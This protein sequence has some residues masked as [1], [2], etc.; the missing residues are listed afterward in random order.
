MMM[1][2]YNDYRLLS[3]LKPT[4][5]PSAMPSSTASLSPSSI[6]SSEPSLAPTGACGRDHGH[7]QFML[8]G[9]EFMQGITWNVKDIFGNVVISGDGQNPNHVGFYSECILL[10]SCY[11]LSINDSAEATTIE[12][13]NPVLY[14]VIIDENLLVHGHSFRGNQ[15]TMF[16]ALCHQNGDAACTLQREIASPMSMFRLELATDNGRDIAWYLQ[17]GQDQVLQSAGPFGSCQVNTYAMCLPREDCYEF[18]ITDGSGD[19]MNGL[20]TVMFSHGNNMVQNYTG[21]VAGT[22]RVYLGSCYDMI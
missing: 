9:T 16:G 7:L 20:Y 21:P 17:N 18:T 10:E 14:T 19:D 11:T 1:P 5:P 22:H 12:D 3:S 13:G 2:T 6:P 4:I 8:E 15:T